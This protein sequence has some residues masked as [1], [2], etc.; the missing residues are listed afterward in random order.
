MEYLIDMENA[1]SRSKDSADLGNA[2]LF[3]QVFVEKNKSQQ[4]LNLY[5]FALYLY[6]N[7]INRLSL[8]S[9]V[10]SVSAE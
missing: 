7:Q 9:S 5:T 3:Q 6:V 8:R 10:A 4:T 2:L 1:I